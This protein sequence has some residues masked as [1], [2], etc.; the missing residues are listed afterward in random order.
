LATFLK[1]NPGLKFELGSHTDAR[2]SD[3]YN[4]T[5]SDKRAKSAVDYMIA[6][7]G[8][9]PVSI[10]SKGYGETQLINK[11]DD[12]VACS[13][14]EHQ[15]NRRTEIKITGWNDKD[16]LWERSLKEIIEDKNLYKKIIEQ[17]KRQKNRPLTSLR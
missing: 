7:C 9:D 10:T 8:V 6:N 13:E 12:G 3:P 11:C 4:L 16:P 17:E 2:G 14:T 15:L 5:L 1:D